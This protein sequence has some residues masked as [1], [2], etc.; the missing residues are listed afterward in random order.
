MMAVCRRAAGIED[1]KDGNAQAQD[2]GLDQEEYPAGQS[3]IDQQ[4]IE[5]EEKEP[6]PSFPYEAL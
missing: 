4:I 2:G 1:L 5:E 6:T 3:E